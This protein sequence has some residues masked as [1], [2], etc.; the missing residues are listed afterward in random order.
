MNLFQS[1]SGEYDQ[2][3]QRAEFLSKAHS[4]AAEILK[5]YSAIAKF[6]KSLYAHI[7]ADR[8][9]GRGFQAVK[10]PAAK[11]QEVIVQAAAGANASFLRK[12]IDITVVLPHFRSFL[13]VTEQNAPAPL[14]DAARSLAEQPAETWIAQ[15]TEYWTAAGLSDNSPDAFA[16]FFPR[17]FLQPYAEFLAHNLPKPTLLVTATVCPFCGSHPY[18]GVLRTEGDSGKRFLVCSFCSQEWE[19]RRILCPTCGEKEELKL[20][21]YV[22]EQFPHLRVEACDTCKNYLRSVDLTKNGHAIPVVDDL[23]ALPLSLWAHEHA[24]SRPRPNL[25]GT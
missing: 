22:P 4:F 16:Q 10:V 25:L 1:V 15:L 14:A 9:A 20:P 12:Q 2:R 24:Y 8:D 7:A 19:F 11:V 6:Q 18:L 13:H 21:V 5:F 3:L 23:A 17:A